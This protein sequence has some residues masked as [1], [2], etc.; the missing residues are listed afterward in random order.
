MK[1]K[2]SVQSL[3]IWPHGAPPNRTMTTPLPATK[4]AYQIFKQPELKLL[5]C[6]AAI[7][8]W[9][10]GNRIIIRRRGGLRSIS[11]SCRSCCAK[12]A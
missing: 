9:K 8:C 1:P 5:E 2:R 3:F 12:L 10:L 7:T 11:P 6:C 4:S